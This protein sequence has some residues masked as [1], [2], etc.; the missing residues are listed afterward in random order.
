[1]PT[2]TIE[3]DDEVLATLDRH[4][5][6]GE[7]FSQT[8]G[9]LLPTAAPSLSASEQAKRPIR[10][11]ED[12]R[13]WMDELSANPLDDAAIAA[14]EEVIAERRS[15]KNRRDAWTNAETNP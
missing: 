11:E 15:P 4:R 1:M 6:G 5:H 7:T 8:I 12:L 13:Q 14:V 10:T 3:I 2:R 9:R